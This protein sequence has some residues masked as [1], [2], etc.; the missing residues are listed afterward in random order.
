MRAQENGLMNHWMKEYRPNVVQCI[1]NTNGG[2]KKDSE[3]SNVQK[4]SLN[5][6]AVAFIALLTGYCVS[7]LV[8]IGEKFLFAIKKRKLATK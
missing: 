5:N 8:L 2:S 3:S 6:L 1:H 4:L 7:L